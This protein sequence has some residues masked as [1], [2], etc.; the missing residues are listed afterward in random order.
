MKEEETNLGV[1]SLGVD[2]FGMLILLAG[3]LW[4][5]TIIALLSKMK[6]N[7]AAIVKQ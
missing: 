2:G 5:C 3:F 6:E 7:S 4:L 1:S